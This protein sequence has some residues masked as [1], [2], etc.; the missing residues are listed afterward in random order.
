MNEVN[1]EYSVGSDDDFE[2]LVADIGFGDQLVAL[3]TQEK[4]VENMRIRIYKSKEMEFWDFRLDDFEKIIHR[5]KTRLLEL[6]KTS[7]NPPSE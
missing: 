5:A 2:D 3:L 1:L 4:G 7:E 6:K